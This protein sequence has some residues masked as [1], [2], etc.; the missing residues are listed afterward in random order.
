[1][2]Y[3]FIISKILIGLIES[4]LV[5]FDSA[6]GPHY[7][8][9]LILKSDVQL[10]ENHVIM[11]ADLPK[12]IATMFTGELEENSLQHLKQPSC[13]LKQHEL[14]KAKLLEIATRKRNDDSTWKGLFKDAKVHNIMPEKP[15]EVAIAVRDYVAKMV[16]EDITVNALTNNLAIWFQTFQKYCLF[17]CDESMS[18]NGK[19]LGQIPKVCIKQMLKPRVGSLTDLVL[20]GGGDLTSRLWAA[21]RSHARSLAKWCTSRNFDTPSRS[22]CQEGAFGIL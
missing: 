18:P 4:V 16:G 19:L 5:D 11:K 6:W 8:I 21:M 2:I 20:P 1:M 14:R 9:E 17:N 3:F 13:K 10:I 12:A 7:G 22:A 15:D